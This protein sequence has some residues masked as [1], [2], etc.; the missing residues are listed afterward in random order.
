MWP[1]IVVALWLLSI[2]SEMQ[3]ITHY[4]PRL[5]RLATVTLLRDSERLLI[6]S[7]FRFVDCCDSDVRPCIR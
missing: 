6:L 5:L 2:L 7:T 3:L 4:F 1:I